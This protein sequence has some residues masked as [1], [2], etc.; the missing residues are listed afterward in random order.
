MNNNPLAQRSPC[1][2]DLR[3]ANVNT[4]TMDEVTQYASWH[5]TDAQYLLQPAGSE[6][7]R[8]LAYLGSI[9][10]PNSR[11]AC[12]ST[13]TGMSALAMVASG[14]SDLSVHCYGQSDIPE[15]A[16]SARNVSNVEI[17]D[18]QWHAALRDIADMQLVV[19]DIEP[20]GGS[21]EGAIVQALKSAGF[22]GIIVLDGIHLNSAM[23]DTWKSFAQSIPSID[24]T[25]VGHWTGTGVLLLSSTNYS[26][27]QSSCVVRT[28]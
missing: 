3:Y 6:P 14:A 12:I 1:V 27:A 28:I 20:H 26:L 7:Y 11:A 2:L 16:L 18:C 19:I 13:K 4:F 9:L 8:L 23:N 10:P 22:A 25:P 24:A 15:D 5:Q 17:H 21:Q